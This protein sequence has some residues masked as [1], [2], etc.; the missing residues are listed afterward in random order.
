[1]TSYLYALAAIISAIWFGV[2]LFMGGREIARPLRQSVELD[3]LVRD[4]QYLCWHFTTVSIA[5][6]S[7]FFFLAYF[8]GQQ[9]YAVA[10]TILAAGFTLTGIGLVS[11]IGQSHRKAPQ[12]WL[13]APITLL[14][15]W[16]LLANG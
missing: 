15:L 14:G 2:H 4:V 9:P 13:F 3:P 6:M 11:A 1:M 12:G 5:A 8:L 10:G 16:G 7:L